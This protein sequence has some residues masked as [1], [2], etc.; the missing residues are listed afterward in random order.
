MSLIL[1]FFMRWRRPIWATTLFL[2]EIPRRI[3]FYQLKQL[4]L[5][6]YFIFFPLFLQW[7]GVSFWCWN[8]SF[9]RL[10]YVPVRSFA[11]FFWRFNLSFFSCILFIQLTVDVTIL[12]SWNSVF[13]C[14]LH[15]FLIFFAIRGFFI[16]YGNIWWPTT[17]SSFLSCINVCWSSTVI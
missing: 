5:S 10:V 16:F 12:L 8:V 17:W 11:R 3:S 7:F 9:L 14:I 4:H 13:I 1:Q 6:S 2:V 15:F